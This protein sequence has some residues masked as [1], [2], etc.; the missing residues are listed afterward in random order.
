MKTIHRADDHTIRIFAVK[1]GFGNDVIRHLQTLSV[2]SAVDGPLS[3]MR[4]EEPAISA[5][6]ALSQPEP[7]IFN[8]KRP[9]E[10]SDGHFCCSITLAFNTLAFNC[11]PGVLS[12][13]Y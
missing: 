4:N 10:N 8:G 1:T 5:A 12:S 13:L 9:P 7:L 3:T 6:M 2:W 11:Q